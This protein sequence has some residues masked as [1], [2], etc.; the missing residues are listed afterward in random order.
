MIEAGIPT[1]I[2]ISKENTARMNI[3]SKAANK[4]SAI[5]NKYPETGKYFKIYMEAKIP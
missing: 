4:L 5:P 1:T 3:W 2:M